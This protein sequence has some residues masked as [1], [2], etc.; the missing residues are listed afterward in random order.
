MAT[1]PDR[2]ASGIGSATLAAVCADLAAR[3]ERTGEIA[4]VSNVRFYGK[5]GAT[6]SRV[7]RGGRQSL[8]APW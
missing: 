7:F 3:G 5:C 1:D 4:W 2:R 6:V 8:R